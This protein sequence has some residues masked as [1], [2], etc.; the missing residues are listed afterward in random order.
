MATELTDVGPTNGTAAADALKSALAREAFTGSFSVAVAGPG[1]LIPNLVCQVCFLE[2]RIDRS[3]D[4]R[5]KT[6]AFP[7]VSFWTASCTN[8]VT[9][10]CV[11]L[12]LCGSRLR[13]FEES[14]SAHVP[15]FSNNGRQKQ[16]EKT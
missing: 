9:W 6:K 8:Y 3:G 11:L 14:R 13:G 12:F 16:R 15:S 5:L 10:D 2:W 1:A 7:T 4:E